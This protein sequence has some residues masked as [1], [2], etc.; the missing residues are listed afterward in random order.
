MSHRG[1]GPENANWRWAVEV[2]L[3]VVVLG[4]TFWFVG[5]LLGWW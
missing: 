3:I 4:G 2:G 1:R 5:V